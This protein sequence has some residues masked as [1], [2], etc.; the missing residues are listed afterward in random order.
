MHALNRGGDLMPQC[1]N[2]M[3]RGGFGRSCGRSRTRIRLL[4]GQ[5]RVSGDRL[6]CRVE[7][8][9]GWEEYDGV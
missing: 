9:P 6:G 5:L 1:G 7:M 8:F 2:M 4:D 3:E